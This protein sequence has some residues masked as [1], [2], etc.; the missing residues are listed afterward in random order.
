MSV[1]R[2]VW[3]KKTTVEES[4]QLDM[5]ELSRKVDFNVA[6]EVTWTWNWSSGKSTSIGIRVEPRYCLHLHYTVTDCHTAEKRDIE[7]QVDIEA[8]PCFY[9][10]QR[11]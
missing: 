3:F 4:T 8:T 11:W 5:K 10:G 9:G 6:S 2:G 1:G 7:Y